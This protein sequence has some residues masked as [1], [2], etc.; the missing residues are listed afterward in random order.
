MSKEY[1]LKRVDKINDRNKLFKKKSIYTFKKH[2][3]EQL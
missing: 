2:K 3:N 1:I